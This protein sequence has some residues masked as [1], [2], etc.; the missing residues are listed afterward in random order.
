MMLLMNT[1]ATFSPFM[2]LRATTAMPPLP[3]VIFMRREA[4]VPQEAAGAARLTTCHSAEAAGSGSAA[5][6]RAR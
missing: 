5:L 3:R 1:F 2:L 6:A 4:V